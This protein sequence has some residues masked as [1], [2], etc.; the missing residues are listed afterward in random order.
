MLSVYIMQGSAS[1]WVWIIGGVIVGLLVFTMA[2]SHLTQTSKAMME[3]RS[4]EQYQELANQINELCWSFSQNKREYSIVLD[5][6]VKGIYVAEDKY[7]E[8]N[9][10][11]HIEMIVNETE[12]LGDYLCIEIEGKRKDCIKLDCKTQMPHLGA[13]PPEFSLSAMINQF[14]GHYYKF[15]YDLELMRMGNTIK[16]MKIKEAE[17]GNK[18]TCNFDFNC[19]FE[20]CLVDCPDCYGPD[21]VCVWDGFCNHDIGENCKNSMDCSCPAHLACCPA[22]P[23]SDMMGCVEGNLSEGERCYCNEC[24]SSLVCNSSISDKSKKYCCPPGKRWNGTNCTS[25]SIKLKILFVPVNWGSGWVSFNNSAKQQYNKILANIPLSSCPLKAKGIF[26]N[27]N[28]NVNFLDGCECMDLVDIENCAIASGES[29]DYVVGL[30]DS[31]VCGSAAGFSC[32]SGTVFAESS[33]ALVSIHELGHE[34]GLNDEYVDACG[35]GFGLVDPSTNCLNSSLDGDDPY[36]GYTPAY[37]TGGPGGSC[38]KTYT[39]TC[40]GNKNPSGGRCIMSFANAPGP[41]E[42]CQECKNHLL[43]IPIINC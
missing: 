9:E 1:I 20:E 32:G 18:S 34:W 5:D 36:P 25:L 26:L 35:C 28:C 10:T 21:P 38:P 37:C 19:T 4:L 3:R 6:S 12:S 8:I 30:E 2:Y 17:E 41:R 13:V 11:E 33:A 29:Y 7:E 31:D 43:T 15:E 24:N 22:S 16:I 14:M 27:T 23:D 39:I 42:F 40:Y